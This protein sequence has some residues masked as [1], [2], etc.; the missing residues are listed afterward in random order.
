MKDPH[1]LKAVKK[2]QDFY[3]DIELSF[4]NIFKFYDNYACLKAMGR[5]YLHIF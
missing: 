2:L 3:P 4:K 5:P 1:V